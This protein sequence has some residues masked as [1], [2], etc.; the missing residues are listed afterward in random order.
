M[1]FSHHRGR[2]RGFSLIEVMAAVL[3][4]GIAMTVMLQLRNDSLGKAADARSRSIAS[5][6]ALNL[7]NRIEAARVPD[8]FDG[9]S[10]DFADYGFPVFS[11][12]IGLGDGSIYAS[13]IGDENSETIWRNQ[14]ELAYED[15]DDSVE[16]PALTRIFISVTYPPFVGEDEIYTLELMLPTWAIYQDFELYQATWP[17]MLPEAIQ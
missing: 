12:V 1:I 4:L 13:G 10:G 9:I 7:A 8:L 11:W 6:M 15:L 2:S 17:G 5:R 16:K 3:L 14:L